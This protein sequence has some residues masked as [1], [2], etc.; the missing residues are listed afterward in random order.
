MSARVKIALVGAGYFSQFH[1]EAWHRIDGAELIACADPDVGKA[2]AFGV[3]AYPSLE[4]I[5]EAMSPDIIDIATPPSTHLDCI[6]TS[7]AAHPRA[8]ICQKPFCGG[9]DD[10]R[11]AADLAAEANI[12]LV[13]HENFRFQPWYRLMRNEIA[14]GKIGAVQNVTFRLR[15]GDGQGPTA[16]LDRQPYFQQMSRFLVHETAVHWIDTFRYLLGPPLAVFA[17]LRQLNPEISG[18]DAGLI[19]FDHGE[20]ARAVFDGNRHLDHPADNPRLTMG[21]AMIEGTD[22]TLFLDGWGVVRV[23][24]AGR[25]EQTTLLDAQEWPGFGGDCVYALQAHVVDALAG[26]G[27]FENQ[28]ADYLHVLQTEEAVYTSAEKGGWVEVSG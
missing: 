27:A 9:L 23:R 16:Y 2:A 13:V 19:I 21:E 7:L 11:V 15:P 3:P 20:G 5:M 25:T 22:G 4:A 1:A 28:A 6:R 24:R 8:V 12:P 14:T 18:E 17:D 26:K 10:A